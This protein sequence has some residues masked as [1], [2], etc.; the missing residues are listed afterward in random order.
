MSG[1]NV[2]LLHGL[3]RTYRSMNYLAEVL[4]GAGYHVVNAD[5]PSRSATIEMLS[6]PAISDALSK[7]LPDK[8]VNFVTHSL[9]GILVRYYL[10]K[11]T[12]DQL[13]R[14]VMLGP[15]NG[16]SEIV[17]YLANA[18]GF[19][20]INGKAGAQLSAQNSAFIN[21]LGAVNFELGVIA[22]TKSLNPIYSAMLPGDDDGKVTVESTKVAGMSDHISLPVSHTFMMRSQQVI[23]QTLHFL[24]QGE[25]ESTTCSVQSITTN[26]NQN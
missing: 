12:I 22:G 9:G 20:L 19:T 1:E 11:H 4:K 3:A 14:V 21:S 18:P 10:S 24:S 23:A 15:P 6:E 2:I 13:K 26:S 17:D 7:C 25:F 5:Y 16:G 8:P